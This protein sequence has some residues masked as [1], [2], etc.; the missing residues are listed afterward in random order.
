MN[1][2]IKITSPGVLV[3][4][5]VAAAGETVTVD[6]AA[7]LRVVESGA[8]RYVDPAMGKAQ[9][10]L[11]YM[12][13]VGRESQLEALAYLLGVAGAPTLPDPEAEAHKPEA[14]KPEAHKAE[15]HK[16]HGR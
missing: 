4:D 8:G 10:C 7:A 14:H 9:L 3:G 15:A 2:E 11:R 5:K 1:H 12:E 6:T 13:S 16:P